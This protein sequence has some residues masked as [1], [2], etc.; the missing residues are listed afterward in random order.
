MELAW[1]KCREQGTIYFSDDEGDTWRHRVIEPE[2]FAYSTIGKLTDQ[3]RICFY[4]QGLLGEGG[5]ACRVF[6][7][8][9][10]DQSPT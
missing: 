5:V 8:A 2:T 1:D 6:T 9:W 7:D 3:Y 10:L 4:S